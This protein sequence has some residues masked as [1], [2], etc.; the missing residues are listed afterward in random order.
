M[1]IKYKLTIPKSQFIDTKIRLARKRNSMV[2]AKGEKVNDPLV[3]E[4]RP[5]NEKIVS[6]AF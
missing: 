4:N 2:G 5:R 3:L 6:N 1:I